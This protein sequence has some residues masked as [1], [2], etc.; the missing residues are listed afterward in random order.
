MAIGAQRPQGRRNARNVK[1]RGVRGEKLLATSRS[2]RLSANGHK[3]DHF[4]KL[5]INIEL[6]MSDI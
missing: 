4:I 1:T 2:V 5:W 6:S 3:T